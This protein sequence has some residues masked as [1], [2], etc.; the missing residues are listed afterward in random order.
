MNIVGREIDGREEAERNEII[1]VNFTDAKK[2]RERIG[3][4]KFVNRLLEDRLRMAEGRA[5]GIAGH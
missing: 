5:R 4:V 3:R 2:R 1:I